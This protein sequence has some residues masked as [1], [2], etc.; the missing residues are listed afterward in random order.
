MLGIIHGREHREYMDEPMT[1][2]GLYMAYTDWVDHHR[3]SR[4]S[5][6]ADITMDGIIGSRAGLKEGV[7]KSLLN[8]V[9]PVRSPEA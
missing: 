5:D 2:Y 9:W 6:E 1:K 3:T 8:K 4:N 7:F